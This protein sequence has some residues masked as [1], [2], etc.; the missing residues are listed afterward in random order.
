MKMKQREKDVMRRET[1]LG[2]HASKMLDYGN[3]KPTLKPR[4]D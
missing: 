2:R 1:E 4:T 3:L